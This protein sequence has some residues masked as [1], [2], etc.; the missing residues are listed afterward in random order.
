MK[1]S[2]FSLIETMIVIALSISMMTALGFLI[3]N[4]NTTSS[5]EKTFMQSSNSA[6][7]V[8]REMATLVVPAHSVL[9][10]HTFSGIPR[11]SSS[12]ALVVGIPSIDNSGN[13][14]TNTYDYA[15]F[16]VTGTN[17]YR[18]LEA[19]ASSRRTS[20]TKQLSAT[21]NSLT[22]GYDAATAASSTIITVDV[23]TQATVKGET[24]SDHRHEQI[25]L[26]NH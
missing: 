23:Q 24:L 18:V 14:I 21:I 16:Y 6:S 10:T 3:Y 25:S 13:I 2:G 7:A 26:R 12:T 8:M 20:D 15:A 5:Y 1:N 19:N 11:T 9:Q 22:F 4:F 17:M